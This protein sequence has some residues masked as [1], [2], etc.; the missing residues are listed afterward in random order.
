MVDSVSDMTGVVHTKTG[1]GQTVAN[2][3]VVYTIDEFSTTW[4]IMEQTRSKKPNKEGNSRLQILVFTLI[5]KYDTRLTRYLALFTM[6]GILLS[7][8]NFIFL[9]ID[10]ISIE[11]GYNFS[12]IAGS[13]LL[14]QAISETLSFLIAPWLLS[15]F[16]RT[17]LITSC[18]ILL[19]LRYFFYSNYYY[20]V[21][22]LPP[23]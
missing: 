7:P 10:K 5:L 11:K 1:Q 20:N 8:M 3:A 4:P 6:V 17:N 14:S 23:S 2:N 16:S 13:V 15:R 9:S 18:L 19:G 12:H 22:R 21:S